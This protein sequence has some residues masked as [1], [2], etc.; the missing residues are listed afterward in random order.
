MRIIQSFWSKPINS[1]FENNL[2]NRSSG[3]WRSKKVFYMAWALSCLQLKRVY[4][5]I[6]LELVTDSEGKKVLI[7]RMK[8][9]YDSVSLEL[10]GL[11]EYD[12][13]LWA[14][15]K[16]RTYNLQKEPF[17]HVDGDV[18]I[19]GNILDGTF[20]KELCAQSIDNRTWYYSKSAKM[21][22]D[23]FTYLPSDIKNYLKSEPIYGVNAGI[24]GGRNIEFIQEY[25]SMAMDLVNRNRANLKKKD[26]NHFN[27]FYE[28]FLFVF[29]QKK[30]GLELTALFQGLS[31]DYKEIIDM[32]MI[33][34]R[35]YNHIVGY[36]K[37]NF[38]INEQVYIRLKLNH[39]S[40]F[41]NIIKQFKDE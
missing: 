4:P 9:P 40:Y 1:K 5:N 25:S 27:M 18:F 19:W 38:I 3:G 23:H 41:Q 30:R 7:D 12:E 20:Q 37:K 2:L 39:P 21:V 28:Q 13:N 17:I 34:F 31:E 15:G 26:M 33:P 32:S 29:L 24:L 16:I 11:N 36:A 8:L 10:D 35:K 6:E 22:L 14:I